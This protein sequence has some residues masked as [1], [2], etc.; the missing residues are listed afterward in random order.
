MRFAYAGSFRKTVRN[1]NS[2]KAE[3][4]LKS[5]EKF[6]SS[7]ESGQVPQGVGF[8]HLRE[9]FFEFRVDIHT[10]VLLQRRGDMIYYILCGNH[11]EIRRFLKRL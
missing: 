2:S 9:D 10:R 11:D 8:K 6:E 4:L 3:K 7:W 5:F 1:L